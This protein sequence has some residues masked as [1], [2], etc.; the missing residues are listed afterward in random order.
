[1]IHPAHRRIL[2]DM[3]SLPTAPFAEGAVVACIER[4]CAARRGLTL[5]RDPVGNILIHLRTGGRRVARPVCLTAHLDHPGFVAERMQGAKRLQAAWRGG[6]RAPY[7]VG[8]RV[9]FFC[10]DRWI[11]GT[12]RSIDRCQEDG[13]ERVNGA[14]LDVE[15]AIARGAPGMWD[16][17]DASITGRRVR[18]R[19]CDDLVGAAAMLCAI[20]EILRRRLRAET[21]FFFTR[22]EEVGFAGALA[23]ARHETIPRRC[24]VVAVETSSERPFARIGDG[25]ILRVGDKSSVFH[26]AATAFCGA[27]AG[28]LVA[29]NPRFRYQRKLMDGGT[30]ESSAYC[31]FGYEATGLC[32]ALGNYHNM[33]LRRRRLAPEYVDVRDVAGLIQWFVELA[34]TRRTY[35]GQETELRRRLARLDRQHRSLLRRTRRTPVV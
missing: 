27:V 3:L 4:F 25:P 14:V 26:S 5:E 20:E 21:Y 29:R 24:C 28:D 23:A 6:V 7:F 13:V 9:R 34:V 32:V 19:G 33:D 10:N 16:F 30:C 35:T 15:A 8:S 17:P 18:A 12:V 22:A 11:R 2:L 1:M 31:Q